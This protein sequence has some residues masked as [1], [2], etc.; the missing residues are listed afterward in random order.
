MQF[1]FF[2]VPTGDVKAQDELNLFLR[3]NKILEVI[4]EF[5]S[6]LHGSA[7]NFCVKYI[8]TNQQTSDKRIATKVDYKKV[9]EPTQFDKF[10]KLRGVRKQI[11]TDDAIPAY[12]V[13]TDEELLSIAQLPE[14]NRKALLSVH[15]IGEKKIEKY[16]N[17]F[18]EMLNNS[19]N[20]QANWKPDVTNS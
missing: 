3:S 11:A 18:I 8:N 19:E 16:G 4:H 10:S 2:T 20:D 17:R 13:F 9:L 7:W 1:K 5:S 14:L 15:G 12:A 6:N